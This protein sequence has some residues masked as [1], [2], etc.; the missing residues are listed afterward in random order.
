MLAVEPRAQVDGAVKPL[1]EADTRS[2]REGAA[3]TRVEPPPTR[4][5]IALEVGIDLD[6]GLRG[7]M[8]DGRGLRRTVRDGRWERDAHESLRRTV[9]DRSVL[10]RRRV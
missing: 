10:R 5:R 7:E 1:D 8:G 6:E 3:A 4:V 2:Q 9:R